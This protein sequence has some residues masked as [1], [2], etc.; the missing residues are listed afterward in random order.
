MRDKKEYDLY[1]IKRE[2]DV[3]GGRYNVFNVLKDKRGEYTGDT[4][5]KSAVSGIFHVS[6]G[7]VNT[8]VGESTKTVTKGQPKLLVMFEDAKRIGV[9]D[10]V[11]VNKSRYVVSDINNIQEYNVVCDLSLEVVLY[12]R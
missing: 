10:L 11:E 12:G 8:K 2:I 7:Y 6:K 3:N 4:E 5:F 9:G 1:R